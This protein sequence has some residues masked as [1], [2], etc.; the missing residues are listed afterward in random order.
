MDF[1]E[2]VTLAGQRQY[3]LAAVHHA[4]RRVRMLG[5]TAHPTHIWATQAIRNPAHGPRRHR[6]LDPDQIPDPRP[7]RQYPALI[8]EGLGTAGIDTVPIGVRMSRMNSIMERWVKTLRAELLD[9]TL[10]WNQAHLRHA[11]REYE[12]HH[13]EHRTHR[14]LA[15]AAPLRVRPKGFEPDQ[16]E[17]L[18]G[19]SAR[20]SR[21]SHPRVSP[22]GLTCMDVVF[23]THRA[24]AEPFEDR[25]IDHQP[26]GLRGDLLLTSLA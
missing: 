24:E 19:R 15:G 14:S 9:H 13:N 6:T 5:S 11:L 16:I 22:C 18:R 12:R 25:R 3:I 26:G 2:M 1:I 7:R 10:I 20:S 23:G 17:R 8:D 21:W 4:S